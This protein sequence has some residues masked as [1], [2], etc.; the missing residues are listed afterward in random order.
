[1]KNS[2]NLTFFTLTVLVLLMLLVS[3]DDGKTIYKHYEKFGESLEWYKKDVR[4]FEIDINEN[5][6]PYLFL[7]TIRVASGYM[8]DKAYVR[9]TE[10]DPQ[11]NK[12][13]YDAGV[14]VRD[15]KGNF[16]GE[17]GFDIIDIEYMLDEKKEFP[18]FGKYTYEVQQM[19]DTADPLIFMMEV[20]LVVKDDGAKSK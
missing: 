20:G 3:C 19:M 12:I 13:S 6:H 2:K 16:Y 5:K 18:V 7:L 14:P 15:E 17:K 8:Y 4:K 1:M 11:D 10:T 9:I